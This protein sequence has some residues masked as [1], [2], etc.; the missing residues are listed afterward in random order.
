MIRILIL[1]ANS[2]GPEWLIRLGFP[3]CGTPSRSSF[4]ISSVPLPFTNAM[5]GGAGTHVSVSA[6]VPA[7]DGCAMAEI[8][9]SD[10][11]S[12]SIRGGETEGDGWLKA[13]RTLSHCSVFCGPVISLLEAIIWHDTQTQ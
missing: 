3:A 13:A 9:L 11:N 5:F 7:L 2:S 10:T 1:P 4:M 6:F 8:S 12:L